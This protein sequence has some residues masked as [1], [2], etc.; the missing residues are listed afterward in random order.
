MSAETGL[1]ISDAKANGRFHLFSLYT[2]FPASVSARWAASEIIKIAGIG[3]RSSSEMWK[4][5]SLTAS[6]PIKRLTAT[7]AANS[8]VIV[9][10]ISSL[11]LRIPILIEWL[12]SLPV[13]PP[14][15]PGLLIGLL[16]EEE[17]NS[18]E[19]DWMLTELMRCAD[20]SN[21]DFMWHWMEKNSLNTPDW[22]KRNVEVLLL[23]KLSAANEIV[24]C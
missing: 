18:P 23:R 21:R 13:P 17:K 3:W 6:A 4:L 24:F 10:A 12:E 11:E 5:D 19:L 16:G 1:R 7:D 15:R 9:V 20:K 22:L 2:D 14:G 8:D